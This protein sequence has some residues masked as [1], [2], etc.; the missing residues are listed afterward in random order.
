[1]A[2]KRAALVAM[3]LLHLLVP[4]AHAT[5]DTEPD[6]SAD[7]GRPTAPSRAGPRA[8]PPRIPVPGVV[9]TASRSE[10]D[11]DTI[12]ATLYVLDEETLRERMVRTLPEALRETPG[13]MVQ[14]TSNGQGS[15]FLRG[16]TGFRTLLLLDGVRINN[17]VLREGPNQYWAT[18]DPLTISRL[19]VVM[20]PTS[21][22]YGSDAIG[23]T[24]NALTR[25]A[26]DSGPGVDAGGR[27]YYR[28][29]TADTSNTYRLEMSG[30]VRD[31]AGLLLGGSYK[32]YDNLDGGSHVGE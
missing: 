29:S 12:P 3:L 31:R 7:D 2:G 14:K 28:F 24:V 8:G 27:G 16:F 32:E 6:P 21:V 5:E 19:E 22:L 4:S 17:S 15:P 13:V 18:I 11:P 26:D 1:M 23:G 30:H 20:G 9:V 25:S 10:S